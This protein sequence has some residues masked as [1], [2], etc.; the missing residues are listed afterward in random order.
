MFVFYLF[1]A[2]TEQKPAQWTLDIMMALMI[3]MTLM[4]SR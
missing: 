3:L 1:L 4:Y 2:C